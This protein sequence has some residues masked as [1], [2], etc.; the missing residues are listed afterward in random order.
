[1]RR[2]DMLRN[3]SVGRNATVSGLAV[4]LAALVVGGLA[5]AAEQETGAPQSAWL[6]T[7][8]LDTCIVTGAKLG[9]MGDPVIYHYQGREIQFCCKGCVGRFESD[10]TAY[11]DKMDKAIIEAEL[12]DYPLQT[13]VVSGDTLGTMGNTVDRVCDNHLVRLCCAGC[14]VE[15]NKD[16]E[17][18]MAKVEKAREARMAERSPKP[19]PLDTCLVSGAKLGS[20][21]DPVTYVYEGQE[22]KFCCAGCLKQFEQDPEKYMKKL[23]LAEPDKAAE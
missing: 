14:A 19:Y 3:R 13:C 15:F 20:M 11:L 7:Y 8:P 2:F 4:F 22:L 12:P 23:P 6:D 9:S 18:Y 21:G 5:L 10:P 16:P 17:K 1:L